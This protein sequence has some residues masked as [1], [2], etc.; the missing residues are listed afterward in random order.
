MSPPIRDGSGS[1]IG[2]IRL[3]DGSEISEVRTGAGDV[4]FS[5]I[6][7]SVEHQFVA[8]TWSENTNWQDQVGT[9]TFDEKGDPTK[10]ASNRNGEDTIGLDGNDD[11]FEDGNGE[12]TQTQ[13]SAIVIVV[14]HISGTGTS[15]RIVTDTSG[16]RQLISVGGN[17]AD[18]YE[19]FAGSN[20]P[21]SGVSDTNWHIVNVLF[22]AGNSDMRIDG[23]LQASGDPG[24]NDLNSPLLGRS[25]GGANHEINVAE[26][27]FM[28][29]P[30]TADRND[31]DSFLSAK[32]GIAL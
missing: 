17:S 14:R 4:L 9:A 7:D 30:T 29:N 22:D 26:V 32:Y 6:P 24:N 15:G 3:G 18:E 27:W 16:N 13:P 8:N 28:N 25:R 2:S 12:I 21:T 5:A 31:A 10:Q 20:T 19:Y 11:Y 23:T 1:S